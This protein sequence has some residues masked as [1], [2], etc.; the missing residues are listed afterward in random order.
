[1][2]REKNHL[3]IVEKSLYAEKSQNSGNAIWIQTFFLLGDTIQF[4]PNKLFAQLKTKQEE[5]L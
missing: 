1:M 2:K 5:E 3:V 4:R